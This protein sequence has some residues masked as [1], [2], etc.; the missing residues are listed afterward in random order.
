MVVQKRRQVKVSTK[1]VRQFIRHLGLTHA[2][3]ISLPFAERELKMARI[4]YKAA[5]KNTDVWRDDHIISLAHA[6]ANKNGT[7]VKAEQKALTHH[8]QQK[9]QAYEPKLLGKN[10]AKEG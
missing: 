4:A 3:C 9:R 5:E 10:C 2:L 7:T 8:A 1:R 6:R